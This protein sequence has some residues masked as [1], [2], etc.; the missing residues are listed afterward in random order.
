[1]ILKPSGFHVHVDLLNVKARYA[2]V[3]PP[4]FDPSDQDTTF[5]I[6]DAEGELFCQT[7]PATHWKHPRLRLYRF[8][9]PRDRFAGGLQRGQFKV[10]DNGAL[11]FRA[12]GTKVPLRPVDGEKILVT[13]RVGNECAR[14]MMDLRTTKK[15]LVFP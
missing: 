9:D 14:E 10:K 6:A 2:N 12:R 7:I 11:T 1:M 4:L 8:R 13:V 15:A 5:Q 3:V